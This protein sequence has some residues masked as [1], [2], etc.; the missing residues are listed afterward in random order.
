VLYQ[1]ARRV[2]VVMLEGALRT[3]VVSVPTLIGQLSGDLRR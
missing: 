2:Q 1:S 3:R